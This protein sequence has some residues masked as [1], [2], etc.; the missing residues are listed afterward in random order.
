MD[1][2]NSYFWQIFRRTKLFLPVIHPVSE[3]VALKSIETALAADADGIF[4]I[5]QGMSADELLQFVPEVHRR[6]GDLWIGVNL[7]GI[8]PAE[9]VFRVSQ[10]PVGG[11]WSDNAMIDEHSEVQPAAELFRQARVQNGWT[12]LYF[13]GVAFKYQREVPDRFLPLAAKAAAPWM[14]AITSSG[15]ATGVPA[16][17]EKVKAL[18]VGADKHPIA[19]ASGIGPENVEQYLPL[20]DAFLVASELETE[21]YSGILVPERTQLLADRIHGWRENRIAD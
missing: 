14:D 9:V 15:P 5:N 2:K 8:Q 6:F 18:R 20:V 12:G 4:L 17:I 19:L 11:I 7:L 10:L 13:G 3:Y 1:Q 21:R 16:S